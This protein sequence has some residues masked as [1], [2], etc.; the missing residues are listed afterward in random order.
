[1]SPLNSQ[2]PPLLILGAGGHA[3]VVVDTLAAENRLDQLLGLIDP[4][5]TPWPEGSLPMAV[6]GGEEILAER[7]PPDLVRLINGLG[8]VGSTEKRSSVYEK[9]YQAGY[10]FTTM[11]HPSAV[12]GQGVVIKDGG[13]IMAGVVVQVGCRLDENV[14]VNTGARIDHDCH[15]AAHVHIAPGAVLSGGVRVGEG[16]HV[17]CG[18]TIIQG[19]HLGR[20]VTV[21]AGAVVI[22]DV[23][24]GA[25]VVG[26]PAA[27]IA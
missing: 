2:R 8:S 13:Q 20:K 22:G 12:L 4:H 7:F 26:V 3:R 19:V 1:M 25:T 6:L 5:P 27:V 24:D 15:L 16:C 10:R 17:G 14:L 21:G 23:P 18:A 9:F 11:V